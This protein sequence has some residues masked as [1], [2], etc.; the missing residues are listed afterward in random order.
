M[1][2]LLYTIILIAWACTFAWA[3]PVTL[4]WDANPEPEVAGYELRYGEVSGQYTSTVQAGK[5]TT[6]TV[7]YLAPGKTYYFA[8]FAYN[9]AGQKSAPSNEVIH[10]VPEPVPTAPKKLRIVID[11]TIYP[12]PTP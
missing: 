3:A 10:T 1:K 11:V 7:P 2:T 12:T 5:N 4:A 9:A 6:I 8:V